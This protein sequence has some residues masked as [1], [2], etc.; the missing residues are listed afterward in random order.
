MTEGFSP[1]V[2]GKAVP[3]HPFHPMASSES[4]N[5][6]LLIGSTRTELTSSS[7]AVAFSFNEDGL[8]TRITK[9][10]GPAAGEAI[11]LYRQANPGATPSDLY[12]LIASDHRYSAP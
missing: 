10:L 5:V 11:E 8:R 2:D 9:L 6:P 7:D 4:A 12:F 3:Q 1:A